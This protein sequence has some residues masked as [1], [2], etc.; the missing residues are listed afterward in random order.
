MGLVGSRSS[1]EGKARKSSREQGT[2]AVS[3][4]K[5]IETDGVRIT[6][7][8]MLTT[9]QKNFRDIKDCVSVLEAHTNVQRKDIELGPGSRCFLLHGLL[10]REE[11]H[12]YIEETERVGFS[13]LSDLFDS[14]YRSN[15][16]LL[17]ISDNLAE[18]LYRR[19]EPHLE[20]RDIVRIRPVGFGN[21]GTWKPHRLNEC[22]KFGK[23][24]TGNE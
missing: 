3:R 5:V 16:R 20:R 21:E 12:F 17:S 22:F 2:A 19:L 11:C 13:S 6:V 8:P 23:Y 14:E 24:Q 15:N 4:C 9:S 7:R 18:G 1:D 10:T